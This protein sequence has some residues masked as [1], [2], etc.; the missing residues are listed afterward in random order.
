MPSPDK[1]LSEAMQL[2]HSALGFIDCICEGDI[3]RNNEI[4]LE[5]FI[6]NLLIVLK[7][8]VGSCRCPQSFELSFHC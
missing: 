7:N 6:L 1:A 3:I 5:E 2:L 4:G 8:Y